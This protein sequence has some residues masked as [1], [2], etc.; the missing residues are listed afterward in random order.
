MD[1]VIVLQKKISFCLHPY[2]IKMFIMNQNLD[3]NLVCSEW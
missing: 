1:A 2:N 3:Q